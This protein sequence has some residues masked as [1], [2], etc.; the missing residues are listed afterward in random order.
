MEV[1]TESGLDCLSNRSEL[2]RS[3][4]SF[5]DKGITVSLFIDAEEAQIRLAKSLGADFIEIH[6]GSYANARH[7]SEINMRLDKIRKASELCQ[8][9]SLGF[10]AGHGLN[11][12]NIY[13]ILDLPNLYE[14]NIGHAIISRAVFTGLTQAVRDMKNILERRI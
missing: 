6:T 5:K 11:Y 12:T 4:R 10:N 3:I 9:L 1:T 14:V 2:E 8:E 7:G 13:P